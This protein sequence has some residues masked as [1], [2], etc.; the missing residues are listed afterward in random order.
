MDTPPPCLFFP[1]ASLD[2]LSH[3]ALLSLSLRFALSPPPSAAPTTRRSA[4]KGYQHDDPY[5]LEA[6]QKR[7]PLWVWVLWQH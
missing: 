1:L 7:T 2:P 3:T 4:F 5:P 6:L